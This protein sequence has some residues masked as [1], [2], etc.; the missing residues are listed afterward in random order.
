MFAVW[1]VLCVFLVFLWWFFKPQGK[2]P[3]KAKK[4]KKKKKLQSPSLPQIPGQKE[5]KNCFLCLLFG[6]HVLVSFSIVVVLQITRKKTKKA[7][8]KKKLEHTFDL[9]SCTALLIIQSFS[10]FIFM[11][12]LRALWGEKNIW[13]EKRKKKKWKDLPGWGARSCYWRGLYFINGYPLG[14]GRV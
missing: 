1:V 12:S 7:K 9:D 3:K 14:K 13:K 10:T 2:K 4:A 8:K 5:R 6:F 11:S